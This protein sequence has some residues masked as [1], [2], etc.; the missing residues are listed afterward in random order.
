MGQGGIKDGSME[1]HRS[2][3]T[4]PFLYNLHTHTPRTRNTTIPTVLEGPPN[5]HRL[6]FRR[7]Q[8]ER[9]KFRRPPI[10]YE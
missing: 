4:F 5:L 7:L 1:Q 8:V 10:I 2:L 9:Y 3:G 6:V